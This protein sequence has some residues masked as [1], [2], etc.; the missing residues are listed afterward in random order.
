MFFCSL[1]DLERVPWL[2][3]KHYSF[4]EICSH[5]GFIYLAYDVNTMMLHELYECGIP[6]WVPADLCTC[7]CS[8]SNQPPN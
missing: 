5:W 8:F 4:E 1:L 2:Q 3:V 6:I 7:R